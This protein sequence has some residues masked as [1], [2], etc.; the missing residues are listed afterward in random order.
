MLSHGG[1]R[2]RTARPPLAAPPPF[3]QMVPLLL[4][5]ALLLPTYAAAAQAACPG[6]KYP[7]THFHCRSNGSTP[8]PCSSLTGVH[9]VDPA[10]C[11]TACASTKGCELWTFEGKAAVAEGNFNCYLKEIKGVGEP[12]P[13]AGA[14]ATSG[15]MLPAPA[16]R[17]APS[18]PAP[19][20]LPPAPPGGFKNVLFIAVDDLRPEI[21]AYGHSYMHT[22]NIDQLAKESTLFTRACES[23]TF[24]SAAAAAPR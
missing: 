13:S 4:S 1:R 11:C 5:L 18:P 19:T 22:P 24:A 6:K 12:H 21:G 8:A 15:V 14:G 16:P 10:A 17:P 2:H 23:A 3:Q 9:V 20:P 7:G